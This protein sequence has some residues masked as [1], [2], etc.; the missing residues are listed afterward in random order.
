MI[1][2]DTIINK[3][4]QMPEPDLVELY[5]IIKNFEA[6]RKKDQPQQSLMAKLRSIKI[7]APSDFSQTADLYIAGEETHE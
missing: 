7:S 5:Q 1:T 4:L 2:R 3:I 6:T